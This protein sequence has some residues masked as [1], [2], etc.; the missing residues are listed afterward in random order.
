MGI[1]IAEKA[2]KFTGTTDRADRSYDAPPA[3]SNLCL[4]KRCDARVPTIAWSRWQLQAKFWST[5]LEFRHLVNILTPSVAQRLRS[6]SSYR[7]GGSILQ[8]PP[9]F[10]RWRSAAEANMRITNA[11][12]KAHS[13]LL[14]EQVLLGSVGNTGEMSR[15][16]FASGPDVRLRP[17]V[18]DP[19]GGAQLFFRCRYTDGASRY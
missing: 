2:T 12:I 7:N 14:T 1:N 6:D 17:C 4:W 18:I 19:L 9:A 13:E 3:F 5:L 11:T 10:R 8:P 15:T 16:R